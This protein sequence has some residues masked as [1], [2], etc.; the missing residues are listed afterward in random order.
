MY[1]IPRFQRLVAQNTIPLPQTPFPPGAPRSLPQIGRRGSNLFF[2]TK[3]EKHPCTRPGQFSYRLDCRIPGPQ[4]VCLKKL[5]PRCRSRVVIL[6]PQSCSSVVSIVPVVD[7]RTSP[8][9]NA[10]P[11]V[12][13]SRSRQNE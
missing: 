7:S 13:Q 12:P 5:L 3:K 8:R 4:N 9:C 6:S 11:A 1:L 10:A 2:K